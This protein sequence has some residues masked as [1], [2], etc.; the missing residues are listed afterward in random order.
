M[1]ESWGRGRDRFEEWRVFPCGQSGQKSPCSFSFSRA[2]DKRGPA[3]ASPGSR[4]AVWKGEGRAI[5]LV[6]TWE[7]RE[8]L[9]EEESGG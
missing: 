8:L 3:G 4:S 1:R 6:K 7:G 5:K 9:W 2:G